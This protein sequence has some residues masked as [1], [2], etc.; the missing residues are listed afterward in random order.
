MDSSFKGDSKASAVCASVATVW[1]PIKP[2]N[3]LQRA[4][5]R[6]GVHNNGIPV[7]MQQY[8]TPAGRGGIT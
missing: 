5:T 3:T 8:I 2:A 1:S 7:D 6:I 4:I